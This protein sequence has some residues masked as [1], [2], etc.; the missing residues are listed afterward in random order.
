MDKD[1][2]YSS[3]STVLRMLPGKSWTGHGGGWLS[4][5]NHSLD[6]KAAMD[7]LVRQW[8]PEAVRRTICA[9]ISEENLYK[10]ATFLALTHD[11]GKMTPVFAAR[12]LTCLPAIREKLEA[13]EL[14]VPVLSELRDAGK[15]PHALAG[16]AILEAYGCPK[17]I[18][19]IVGAHH[20]KPIDKDTARKLQSHLETYEMNYYG[21]GCR[22]SR[23]GELW[24]SVRAEWMRF[25][26][27]RAGYGA[28]EE[29]PRPS[30][31]V[32]VLLTGLLIMA[33]W[34]ASNPSYFPLIDTEAEE[35]GILYPE[36]GE[37]ALK[38]LNLPGL[39]SPGDE[40]LAPDVFRE[41]FG[42][43]PNAV[44]SAMLDAVENAV[45]PGIFILEAQ[46]GVGKTEA[47]LAAAEVLASRFQEG[48]LFFGLPTQATANGIFPRLKEW[49]QRQPRDC[50]QAI[51]LAHGM[52]N[53]NE[54]YRALFEGGACAQEDSGQ[55]VVHPWFDG[56]KQALLANFVIG[57]VDQ[58]LMAALKQKHV[59]LRHLGL[60]GKVVVI[61]EAHAYD[62]Y[63]Q[64]YLDRALAWLGAY[65]VPVILLS[66]TLPAARRAQLVQAYAGKRIKGGKWETARDYPL[67]TWTDGERA[68][69][70]PIARNAAKSRRVR[71]SRVEDDGMVE[72]MREALSQGGCAGVIVNTVSRAQRIGRM[73]RE[74]LPDKEV[75]VVHAHYLAAD[76]AKWEARLLARL[77][78]RSAPAQRNGLIVVGTQVIEQSLDLDFDVLFTDLC[79]MD[80]LLQRVGRLHRHERIRPEGV[81]EARCYVIDGEALESGAVAVYGEWLLLRTRA[82]LPAEIAL[83]DSIPQLVQDTYQG[84]ENE[85]SGNPEWMEA[86]QKYAAQIKKKQSRAKA[87]RV[88]MPNTQGGTLTGWLDTSLSDD[89]R[90][91]E[92]AVRD[93]DPSLEVLVMMRH[94]DGRIGFLPWQNDGRMVPSDH[95]PSSE[96][97][98]Q[99]ASQRLRLPHSFCG[100]WNI[101][102]SIG[103]L[104]HSTRMYVPEWQQSGWLNGELVLLLDDHLEARLCGYVLKYQEEE[105]LSYRR[106]E[107]TSE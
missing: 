31:A 16:A 50:S 94:E 100:E 15:S 57:T 96:E 47:A 82:L 60:A 58:L 75:W 19:A 69:S 22:K 48:G 43:F 72:R 59:M 70:R 54:E 76:R 105:G 20:G 64:Q 62:V 24:N 102:R 7:Y 25:A 66:A 27:S 8:L 41:R 81:G 4:C 74:A 11:I 6:S 45:Q 17:E 80:L 89:E 104:E 30:Q 97:A 86:Y 5:C 85:P 68:V 29:L 67:L 77:G 12:I 56:R 44:Q 18:A 84:I 35:P 3:L 21:K 51:R 32:Q 38:K 14:T 55:L 101:D 98:R 87:Y 2:G 36:R 93:G 99:I 1:C 92:A 33:D 88:G 95:V 61:D 23:E 91:A 63:I 49:A 34:I 73:L 79:P 13:L 103:E 26:L 65:G 107:E 46:M 90:R 71:L 40:V 106:E 52:A 78:R 39:W 53:L 37:R 10:L 83:P 42:F 28:V 9:E